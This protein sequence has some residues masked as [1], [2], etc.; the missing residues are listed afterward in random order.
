MERLTY[1]LCAL[2]ALLCAVL[3]LRAW[4]RARTRL[5]LWSGLCFAGLTVNNVLLVLDRLV[6]VDF[7]L[8]LW[9]QLSALLSVSLLVAG[10]VLEGD[11]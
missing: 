7:D 11:R 6:F 4:L 2:A 10:L 5:L 1:A 8:S 9:R 3:L